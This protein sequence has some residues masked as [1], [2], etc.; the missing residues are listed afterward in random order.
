[1]ARANDS[2]PNFFGW[3]W[4]VSGLEIARI[5]ATISQFPVHDPIK[6]DRIKDVE[7]WLDTLSD[8]DMSAMDVDEEKDV[9]I[10]PG[11]SSSKDSD[12]SIEE[13][14]ATKDTPDMDD[15]SRDVELD[16]WKGLGKDI[17][18]SPAFILPLILGA[19]ENS[20]SKST[21]S[22]L[23][24]QTKSSAVNG[25]EEGSV[26]TK[27]FVVLTQRLVERGALS[28]ALA[29][30]CSECSSLRKV[31]VA[32]LAHIKKALDTGEARMLS[33][34]RER[35]QL[36]M[37]VDSVQ[38]GLAVR[39]AMRLDPHEQE[40]SWLNIPKLPALSA[41]FL[42]RAALIIVKPGDQM[43]GPINRYFLR[44][45]DGHGAFQDTNRL[46]AFISL[47]CSSANEPGQARRER[48]WAL[49]L[50]KDSFVEEYCYRMIESCHAPELVMSNF[51]SIRSRQEDDQHDPERILLIDTLT[52]I[53]ENGGRRAASHLIGRLGLLSWI[54]VQVISDDLIRLLP[55]V[56]SRIAFLRL[57]SVALSMS[58]LYLA[59]EDSEKYQLLIE[60]RSMISDVIMLYDDSIRQGPSSFLD[61]RGTTTPALLATLSSDTLAVLVN[62]MKDLGSS[63]D[64]NSVQK[65]G[66]PLDRAIRMLQTIP[67]SLKSTIILSLCIA[68]IRLDEPAAENAVTFCEIVLSFLSTIQLDEE[69]NK[70]AL[71]RVSLLISLMEKRLDAAGYG[72]VD[73]LLSSRRAC[74]QKCRYAWFECLKQVIDQMDDYS[75]VPTSAYSLSIAR[76]ILES[77]TGT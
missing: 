65:Y 46:P 41:V 18:Y 39:V 54:R 23:H 29:S 71:K 5:R 17:R 21:H 37:I 36:A 8:D 50:M 66:I 12:V 75:S 20:L 24:D 73:S 2:S 49:Q 52:S 4:L 70:A 33:T 6:S 15:K 9:D 61:Q 28:L 68:P 14:D 1:M 67:Q 47:F 26:T 58:R 13:G 32:T 35:P 44:L 53:L 22:S 56:G 34:W 55:S 74:L 48:L 51:Q 42:A 16:V 19:L 69:T 10:S 25:E 77:A 63:E 64:V 31:A 59:K 27:E 40:P 7:S 30:L 3:D 72:L 60:S 45:D 62:I 57:T 76:D 43:F 38:R 11:D